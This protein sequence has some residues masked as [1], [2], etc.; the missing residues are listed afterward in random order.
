MRILG[1]RKLSKYFWILTGIISVDLISTTWGLCTGVLVEKSLLM[2]WT[3]EI[4]IWFLVLYKIVL[5]GIGLAGLETFWQRDQLDKWIYPG[6]IVTYLV[7]WFGGI[8]YYQVKG[9]ML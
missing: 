4:G 8:I 9:M 3:V 6:V 2:A 1:T 5:S 7:I